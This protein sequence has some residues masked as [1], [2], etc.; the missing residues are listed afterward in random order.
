[1]TAGIVYRTDALTTKKV[2]I[3]ETLNNHQPILYCSGL[4]QHAN[5]PQ[6][7]KDF[8]AY[9]LSPSAASI[10]QKYGFSPRQP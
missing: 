5:H 3:V 9:L 1:V 10:L 2:R 6:T 8:Q 4:V 7:A